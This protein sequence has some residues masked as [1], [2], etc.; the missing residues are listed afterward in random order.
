MELL[1]IAEAAQLTGRHEKTIRRWIKKQ[2]DTDPQAKE[3]IV[4]ESI[5]SGFTYRID[6]D[7]LLTHSPTPLD[8]PPTQDSEHS[9][10]QDTRQTTQQTDQVIQAK[11]E[12]IAL[13]KQQ[14]LLQQDQLKQKDD[15]IKTILERARETNV[16]LK[17][18]QDKL[19]LEAPQQKSI[20]S[21]VPN[22]SRQSHRQSTV[23]SSRQGRQSNM[24]GTDINRQQKKA[25]DNKTEAKPAR[26]QAHKAE[27]AKEE[28]KKRKGFF[29]FLRRK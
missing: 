6:K 13:L 28:Q 7:Y 4:Q 3:K 26:K 2:F 8:S 17:G 15:Q 14:I 23:R 20:D 19:L 18:Y 21:T 24:T 10:P 25:A 27:S 1:S 9:P 22:Q 11:D 5:A 16:L 12:T 29:S